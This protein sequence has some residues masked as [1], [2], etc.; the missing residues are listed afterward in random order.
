[1]Y[2]IVELSESRIVIVDFWLMGKFGAKSL[3]GWDWT[4]V[5]ACVGVK[6]GT[7]FTG[8]L[9]TDDLKKINP[10]IPRQITTIRMTGISIDPRE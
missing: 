8:I 5:A 2:F 1:M 6:A 3:V 7:L 9:C 4:D 10:S